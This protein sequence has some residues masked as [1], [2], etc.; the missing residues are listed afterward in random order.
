MTWLQ[1]YTLTHYLRNSVWI[2][3]VTGMAVALASVI[4]LH[5]IEH[6]AGWKASVD[7]A[8]AMSLFGT[9]AGAMLTFIVFLSSSLLLVVQLASGQLSPRIIGVIFRDAVTRYAL[10]LF[11]FTFTFTLAVLIRIQASV[12]AITPFVAGCLYLLSVGVFLFLI[13]HVGKMLRSSGALKA[14]A[15]LG[16]EVI[17]SVYPLRDELALLKRAAQRCFTEPE[18]K[19]LADVSDLQ[20]MGGKQP[21]DA[22][23]ASKADQ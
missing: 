10:T 13:D 7:P 3:P 1:H 19:A 20:G 21:G 16:H 17:Q 18:D 8:A 11:A 6:R 5:W 15:R 4:G 9:L 22:A 23:T 2:L 14:V 12:P